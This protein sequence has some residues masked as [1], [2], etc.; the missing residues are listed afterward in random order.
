MRKPIEIPR[1][2]HLSRATLR[3]QI[4]NEV[5]PILREQITGE[6]LVEVNQTIA[7]IVKNLESYT[8]YD[9]TDQIANDEII[10]DNAPEQSTFICVLDGQILMQNQDYE[11][12]ADTKIKL[13]FT[14]EAE[15]LLLTF[16]K[17][18]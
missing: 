16:Y 12:T 15:S 18:K 10:L 4:T 17:K 6:V 5:K 2:P 14:P 11:F 13:L 8:K 9:H 3:Q 7:D 1:R